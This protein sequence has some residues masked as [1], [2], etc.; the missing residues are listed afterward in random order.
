MGFAGYVGLLTGAG[1]IALIEYLMRRFD[2]QA[3]FFGIPEV[4][5]GIAVTATVLLVFTGA[6]AG[7]IP[8]AKAARVNP[9]VA[10]RDE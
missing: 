6:L 2:V 5:L 3:G 1:I 8:A 10:L 7:L 4:N 9:V